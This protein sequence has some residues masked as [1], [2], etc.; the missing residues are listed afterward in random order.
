MCLGARVEYLGIG[1]QIR[2]VF[3]ISTADRRLTLS[4]YVRE[5]TI[6]ERWKV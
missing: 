2:E 6:V 3:G 4:R 5:S 1:S